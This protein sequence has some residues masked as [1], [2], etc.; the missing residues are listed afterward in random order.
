[1]TFSLKCCAENGKILQVVNNRNQE[2]G[3]GQLTKLKNT[4]LSILVDKSDTQVRHCSQNGDQRLNGVAVDD[5][6]I[7]FEVFYSE[8]AFVNNPVRKKI[9][10]KIINQYQNNAMLRLAAALVNSFVI[11][12]SIKYDNYLFLTDGWTK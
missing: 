9:E 8:A 7:L 5:R 6:S 2:F 3:F 12:S 11:K 1:M 10:K 4:H